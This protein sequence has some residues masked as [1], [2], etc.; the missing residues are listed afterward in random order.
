MCGYPPCPVLHEERGLKV[1][2]WIRWPFLPAFGLPP[3]CGCWKSLLGW[4]L[5][6]CSS[7]S[8]KPVFLV[9]RLT[10][11]SWPPEAS[12]VPRPSLDPLR[13]CP[14]YLPG[15]EWEGLGRLYS[16]H[17]RS[18]PGGSLLFVFLSPTA[19]E[20]RGYIW[21]GIRGQSMVTRLWCPVQISEWEA[22]GRSMTWLLSACAY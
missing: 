2:R 20:P 12:L 14:P 8:L 7:T 10:E 15:L 6:K 19:S 1:K 3:L 18:L 16:V 4:G 5:P 21:N 9:D 11:A 22:V 13:L 17:P